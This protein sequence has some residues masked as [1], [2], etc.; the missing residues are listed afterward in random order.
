LST[1]SAALTKDSTALSIDSAV[2]SVVSANPFVPPSTDHYDLFI[3]LFIYLFILFIYL[4][5]NHIVKK[6]KSKIKQ[7]WHK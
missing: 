5:I 4:L 3:Y 1:Y 2:L 6:E 7:G